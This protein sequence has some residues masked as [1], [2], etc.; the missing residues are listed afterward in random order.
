MFETLYVCLVITNVSYGLY[1]DGFFN[2]VDKSAENLFLNVFLC[3]DICCHVVERST[4]TG[5]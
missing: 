1:K 3:S 2:F 4:T 5:Q